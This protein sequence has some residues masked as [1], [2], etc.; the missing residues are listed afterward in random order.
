MLVTSDLSKQFQT[1]TLTYQAEY[2][3]NLDKFLDIANSRNLTYSDVKWGI[4]HQ[5]FEFFFSL[6]ILF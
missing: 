4:F 2:D 5:I 1:D 6:R 3:Q